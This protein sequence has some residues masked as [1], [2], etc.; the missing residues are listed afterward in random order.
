MCDNEPKYGDA[1]YDEHIMLHHQGGVLEKQNIPSMEAKY[2][3]IIVLI[4][5][6]FTFS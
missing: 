6:F 3:Y 2:I 1:F 4:L 5:N